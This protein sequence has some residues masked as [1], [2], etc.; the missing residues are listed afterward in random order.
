MD[1]R[2]T[3]DVRDRSR[4]PRSADLNRRAWE[5]VQIA[6]GEAP[7]A[8]APRAKNAAAV[9]L[10]RLGG[11]KGGRARAAKLSPEQRR[12]SARRAAQARWGQKAK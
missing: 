1:M 2:Y 4:R 10:G 7:P 9:E 6:T 3:G 12:E 5:I 11:K 8:E